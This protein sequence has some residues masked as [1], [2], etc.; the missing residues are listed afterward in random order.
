MF[1]PYSDI[2]TP[3][4][5]CTT[6]SFWIHEECASLPTIKGL[7]DHDHDHPLTL[8]YQLPLEFRRY[9]FECEFCRKVL[10]P[11]EWV[12]YC[13]RCRYFVHVYCLSIHVRFGSRIDYD[14]NDADAGPNDLRLPCNDVFDEMIKPVMEK[15]MKEELKLLPEIKHFSHSHP[16]ILSSTQPVENEKD[17]EEMLCD[18]CIQPISTPYYTCAECK[19]MLHLT[20][21]NFSPERLYHVCCYGHL[22]TLKK[23]RNELGY[24][25]CWW[26]DT[27][28]NGFFF[29]CEECR[30]KIH[31]NCL[32][33]SFGKQMV[34]KLHKQHI[35][36]HA[37]SY[38]QSPSMH[39]HACR[40]EITSS[41]AY[42][43]CRCG[44]FLHQWCATL[45]G[46]VKH[47][48]DK[49]PILLM[50]PPFSDH[51]DELY[52]EVCKDEIHPKTWIYHCREC[53]QSFHP[54]CIPRLGKDGNVKFGSTIQV[55]NHE[56]PLR[57]VRKR[58]TNLPAMVVVQNLM[59]GR[60]GNAKSVGFPFP[61]ALLVSAMQLTLVM[62]S[63]CPMIKYILHGDY[64]VS[65]LKVSS[66]K[67]Y[68]L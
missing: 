68:K 63:L 7:E 47:R 45:P 8:A 42:Y 61:C 25:Y 26:C 51:P 57:S 64:I 5:M 20:C 1:V 31:F 54:R 33:F 15:R 19:Y 28:G 3:S 16:L 60:L 50:H 35:L 59:V 9:N 30:I 14:H 38:R 39:C 67:H 52:C 58:D 17:T 6:C 12:Y 36:W 34:Y 23:F 65:S 27:K 44:F 56:H 48:W 4:Y 66:L 49:H 40:E 43:R 10:K 55:A 2:N 21:A 46:A 37:R 29:D 53:D 41:N 18:G 11:S 22:L 13:G 32:I 62:Y 24:F